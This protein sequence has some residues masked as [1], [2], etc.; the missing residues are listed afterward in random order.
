MEA[1]RPRQ[2]GGADQIT[3]MPLLRV[4]FDEIIQLI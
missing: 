3:R 2:S 4:R 1:F